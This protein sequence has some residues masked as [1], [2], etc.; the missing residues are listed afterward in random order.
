MDTAEH[1]HLSRLQVIEDDAD[2]PPQKKRNKGKARATADDEAAFVPVEDV[3]DEG[4]NPTFD[5]D[6][7][8]TFQDEAL[9]FPDEAVQP[10]E[11]GAVAPDA[12]V[13]KPQKGKEKPKAKGKKRARDE[14]AA[15][16][17]Q[18]D[19]VASMEPVDRA[20]RPRLRRS[21]TP[22]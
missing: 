18:D 19:E 9:S 4:D 8:L 1:A 3:V 17:H 21:P 11:D 20:S 2:Q 22:S 16:A 10:T 6:E 5:D 13:Q 15:T 14:E 12:E 7:E